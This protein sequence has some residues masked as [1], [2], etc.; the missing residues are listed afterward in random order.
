MLQKYILYI[1]LFFIQ[2]CSYQKVEISSNNENQDIYSILESLSDSIV[3]KLEYH[4]IQTLAIMSYTDLNE[5]NSQMGSYISDEITLQLFLK[6][7]Y[8][9]IEREQIDYVIGEQKLNASGLIN[10]TSAIE[11]GNIL[12]A[13][14]II[15]GTISD[16]NNNI[17]INTKV[18]SSITGEI[19]FIDKTTLLKTNEFNVTINNN[20]NTTDTENLDTFSIRGENYK[21]SLK[22]L[23]RNLIKCIENNDYTC[24]LKFI[25]NKDQLRKIILIKNRENK[26][27][28]RQKI[29]QLNLEYKKYLKKNKLNFLQ[30]SNHL[31]KRNINWD[32]LKI[33]KISFNVI[34]NYDQKKLFEIDLILN[35][36]KKYFHISYKAFMLNGK[37]IINDIQIKRK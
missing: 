21:K 23:S 6:E 26:S 30:I 14:A 35:D 29:K 28:R 34:K 1:S 20:Q 16:V 13:D 8:Q 32:D 9:I 22:K 31:I 24:Y 19:I 17:I 15:L 10:E 36:Q 3:K 7:K 33:E 5:K 18:V 11:I 27:D 12:S 2:F 37:W 4:E 25:P